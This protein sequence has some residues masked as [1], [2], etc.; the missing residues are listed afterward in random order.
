VSGQACNTFTDVDSGSVFCPNVEWLKNRQVTL[1]CTSATLYC[2]TDS[3]V[4]L[5]MAAFMN[6]LGTALTGAVQAT[7]ASPGAVSVG[8]GTVVCQTTGFVASGF[9]RRA[10]VDAVFM[11]TAAA[12]TP[13]GA[14][15]VASFD[16]GATWAPLSG[17]ASR[18]TIPAG[19][20]AN[21]RAVGSQDV[22]VG[23]TVRFGL[24]LTHGGL[25]GTAALSDSRCNLR[26]V[27]GNRNSTFSPFDAAN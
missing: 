11:G 19:R 7:E 5:S 1:G 8:A 18:S 15:L 23:Q 26:A 4:R 3:V 22:A 25:A 27:F 20:W 12:Q 14:D 6:R 10:Q 17:T 9:A 16:A 13:F 2:P 24:L 21:V